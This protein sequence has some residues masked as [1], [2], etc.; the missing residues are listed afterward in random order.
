M[1]C[2]GGGGAVA[3]MEKRQGRAGAGNGY[4]S[5]YGAEAALLR[6]KK[7]AG[8]TKNGRWALRVN[9]GELKAR[10]GR[11][12]HSGQGTGDARRPLA[13][14]RHANSAWCRP[15]NL[16]AVHS[17]KQQRCLTAGFSFELSPDI[18]LFNE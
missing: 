7:E 16:V 2:W 4:G 15:L 14:T 1:G 10:P 13:S 17:V 8:K 12:G 5:C 9:V 18:K 3:V 11:P 6:A